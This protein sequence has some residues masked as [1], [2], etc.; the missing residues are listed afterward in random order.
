MFLMFSNHSN[1]AGL[2]P[3]PGSPPRQGHLQLWRAASPQDPGL[4]AGHPPAVGR[5]PP[6]S[7]QLGRRRK[8]RGHVGAG[9][10]LFLDTFYG[11][12]FWTLVH[13]STMSHR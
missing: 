10:A 5:R 8:I 13:D 1:F 9:Q 4:P 12:V 3:V 6:D 2:P 7:L 11:G